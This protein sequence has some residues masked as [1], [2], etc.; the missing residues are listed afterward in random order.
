M[1]PDPTSFSQAVKHSTWRHAMA[2]EFNAFVENDTWEL[3][4]RTP[5][6]N[7][8]SRKWIFKAKFASGRSVECYKACLVTLGNH[9]QADI[10]Y[11]ETL[12]LV[13]KTSTVRLIL[14]MAISCN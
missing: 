1:D 5:P 8:V 4:P 13:V 14:S 9:Q 12:S 3:V 7:V 2:E 6:M 11:H 10:D